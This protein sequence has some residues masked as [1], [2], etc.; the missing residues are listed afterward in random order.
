MIEWYDCQIYGA[1]ASLVFSP[2][3]F[4]GADPWLATIL[5]FATFAARP[6]RGVVMGHFGD[7]LGERRCW[8]WR[9]S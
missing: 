7:S 5:S 9:W 4:Y 8:Y 3:F 2:L 6:L 1:S